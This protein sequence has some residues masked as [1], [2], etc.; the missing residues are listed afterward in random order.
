MG[1]Y[2]TSVLILESNN[3]YELQFAGQMTQPDYLHQ[4]TYHDTSGGDGNSASR[5]NLGGERWER[6]GA[7]VQFTLPTRVISSI[8][9]PDNSILFF[10]SSDHTILTGDIQVTLLCK[11]IRCVL[12]ITTLQGE[13][14]ENQP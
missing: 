12:W 9:A 11:R 10:N 8:P 6:E 4:A 2:C 3:D 5:A 13:S 14:V 1:L 7:K